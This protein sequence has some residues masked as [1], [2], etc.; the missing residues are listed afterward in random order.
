MR[1][2]SLKYPNPHIEHIQRVG[3]NK[4]LKF[5]RGQRL[6]E[7]LTMEYVRTHTN[8]PVPRVRSVFYVKG[9]LYIAMDYIRKAV[10]L[11][12][13][14]ST[15]LPAT[16][17][18]IMLELKGYLTTLRSLPPPHPGR[19]ESINGE[20]CLEPT[21]TPFGSIG[22][23]ENVTQLFEDIGI[24]LLLE[25]TAQ[26][27]FSQTSGADVPSI[28]RCAARAASNTYR[29][30]LTHGDLTPQN[31]LIDRETDKIV[32][33][34]DWELAGWYPDYWEN[35]RAYSMS[36]VDDNSTFFQELGQHHVFAP[37]FYGD[38]I[39]MEKHLNAMF[40]SII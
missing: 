9:Q 39:I 35:A 14:W 22:P 7:A 37:D 3:K 31:I 6:C 2:C 20:G 25:Q 40:R 38:E 5:K 33:I 15:M 23:Y 21:I 11:S 1:F 13:Q 34:I 17:Q 30:V 12:S 10:T 4:L 27:E 8:I 32:S 29:T 28:R 16:K 36:R 19:I 24:N 26:E 18:A